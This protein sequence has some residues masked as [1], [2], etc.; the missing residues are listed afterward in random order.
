MIIDDCSARGTTFSYNKLFGIEEKSETDRE[1]EREGKETTIDRTKRLLYVTCSRAM[2]SLAI[3][4]YTDNATAAA[5][6]M[7]QAGWF[8]QDEIVVL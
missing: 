5:E 7:L 3:V 8:C 1:N 6:K 2:D 4:Y